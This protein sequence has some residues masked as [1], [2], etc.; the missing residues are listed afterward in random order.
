MATTT[1]KIENLIVR[2]IAEVG[3]E[4]VAETMECDVSNISRVMSNQQG[5]LLERMDEFFEILGIYVSEDSS[6]TQEVKLD[7]A[8]YDAL[9]TLARKSLE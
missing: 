9:R 6:I 2:R 7:Q 1:R 4:S 3:R 8:E 5:M